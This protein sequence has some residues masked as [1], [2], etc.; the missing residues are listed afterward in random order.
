MFTGLV[1]AMGKIK[2]IQDQ[3]GDK[4]IVIETT[5][6]DLKQAK[7]GDSI[8]VSGVC[9]TAIEIRASEFTADVS[10]ET[11]DLTTAGDWQIGSPV[12]LEKSLTLS[13][14]LGGHLVSGHVDGIAEIVAIAPDARSTRLRLQVPQKLAHYIA[15]KGSVCLDG[16]SLTV[17]KVEGAEFEI[18]LVPHTLQVTT[19]K[20]WQV[21]TKVNL[22][23]DL[24]A[25][26]LERLLL[27]QRADGGEKSSIDLAFLQ[28]NGFAPGG[29]EE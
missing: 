3:G 6:L 29:S 26:Y 17:N 27:G 22:E 28:R 11:L 10:N 7:L 5:G 15:A 13:T 19:L 20:A 8:A 4:R 24:V 2:S 25:R 23:V 9:L 16:V 21:G 1:Q 12:N 18:N 14:P